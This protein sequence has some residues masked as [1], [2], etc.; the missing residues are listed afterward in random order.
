MS[1]M[2]RFKTAFILPYVALVVSPLTLYLGNRS[3]FHLGLLELVGSLLVLAIGVAAILTG[4]LVA[5]RKRALFEKAI[6]GLLVGMALAAWA[7]SQLF[8]WDFG[9]LDGRAIEW[10]KWALQANLELV[11]WVVAVG[12]CT[13]RAYRSKTALPGIAQLLLILGL[14]SLVSAWISADQQ[15]AEQPPAEEKLTLNFHPQNNTLLIIL[16]TLQADVF[17]EVLDRYPEETGFLRG[18][19]FFPNTVGG[20]PTTRASIPLIVS[21]RLY[22]NL[23]PLSEWRRA[24]VSSHNIIDH[25]DKKGFG[26][27]LAG[28][29]VGIAAVKYRVTE[30]ATLDH[31][32]WGRVIDLL[33]PVLDGGLFRVAP[34]RFKPRVYDN[35]IYSV[36]N[37]AAE[38]KTPPAYHGVDWRFLKY[39]QQNAVV[40][41][42][43]KGEFKYWHLRGAHWP[44]VVNEKYEYEKHMPAS[45]DSYIRQTR[46]VLKLLKGLLEELKKLG[47]YQSARI[48]VIGDHG[49]LSV[50]PND[51]YGLSA[52]AS[53]FEPDVLSSARPVLLHKRSDADAAIKILDNPLHLKDVV[54]LLSDNDSAFDCPDYDLLTDNKPRSRNFLFYKWKHEFWNKDYMPK[55]YEYIVRGDVR[56]INAWENTHIEYAEGSKRVSAAPR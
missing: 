46:G 3:E 18:F 50:P 40:E 39:L 25:F 15:L 33:L 23:M 36:L 19:E 14:V 8:L 44:L 30:M 43:R 10:S 7:Q 42:T 1:L 6:S 20:Y 29:G 35:S 49:S 28:N 24:N 4:L 17:H 48:L 12:G 31:H 37:F 34:T 27:S 32:V 41:S 5:C 45:R 11:F 38:D 13:Q 52:A 22:K 53:K 16:D 55:M 9:P 56:D 21:G 47:V 51:I 54:C 26:L 2:Q